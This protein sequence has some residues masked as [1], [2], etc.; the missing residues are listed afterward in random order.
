MISVSE[1][2]KKKKSKLPE[3]KLLD[4]VH[5]ARK[6]NEIQTEVI[7]KLVQQFTIYL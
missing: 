3:G 7:F 4:Q 1:M 5:R 6:Q 2:E